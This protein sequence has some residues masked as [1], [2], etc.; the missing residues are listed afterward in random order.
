MVPVIDRR[1]LSN[2]TVHSF[3]SSLSMTVILK[4]EGN[5]MTI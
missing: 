3:Q 5:E 2:A 4:D 1:R